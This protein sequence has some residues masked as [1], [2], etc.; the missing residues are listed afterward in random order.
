MHNVSTWSAIQTTTVTNHRQVGAQARAI[1]TRQQALSI[2][3]SQPAISLPDKL[4]QV[5]RS[6]GR[7]NAGR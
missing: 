2:V 4:A 3:S 7:Q 6:L 1:F 5:R